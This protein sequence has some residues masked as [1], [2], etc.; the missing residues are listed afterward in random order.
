MDDAVNLVHLRL[1]APCVIESELQATDASDKHCSGVVT[2]TDPSELGKQISEQKHEPLAFLG[3]AFRDAQTHWS[4]FEKEAFAIFKT[5][6]RMDYLLQSNGPAHIFTDHRNLLFVFAPRALEPALGRHIVS[7]VQRWALY[8]SRFSYII[9]HIRGEDNAC[10]DM[11][12]RWT[13]GHRA[14]Q[15]PVMLSSLV[16]S[17]AEQMVPRPDELV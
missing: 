8:L 6:E 12:T 14:N 1:I 10:A 15:A 3:S 5:F 13:R 7:K 4:T 11:L 17:D 9:E 2:Q 16:L